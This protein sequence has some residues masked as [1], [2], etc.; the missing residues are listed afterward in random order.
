MQFGFAGLN[1]QTFEIMSLDT[2]NDFEDNW[3][4]GAYKRFTNLK[5]INPNLK[6]YLAIGGWNEG[7]T[8]YS[9]MAAT[10]ETRR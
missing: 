8:K 3:G 10:P 6:T 4:R 5:T 7:S 1:P 2:Y 9:N